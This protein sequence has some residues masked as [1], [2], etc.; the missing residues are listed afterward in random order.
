M[1]ECD[2][3]CLLLKQTTAIHTWLNFK[4][5][6]NLTIKK[7][8]WEQNIKEIADKVT[9]GFLTIFQ[10]TITNKLKQEI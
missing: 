10:Q 5:I 8:G 1:K 9:K 6:N 4:M 2:L 7:R 3:A